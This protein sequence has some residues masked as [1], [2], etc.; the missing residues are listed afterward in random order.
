VRRVVVTGLGVVTPIGNDVRTYWQNLLAGKNGVGYITRFDASNFSVKIAAEVRNFEPPSIISPKEL[1]R[2]DLFNVFAIQ[3]AKEAIEDAQL[4]MATE[5]PYRVGVL[6][7]SGIGG[8]ELWEKQ[9]MRLLESPSKVSPFFIP[10][11]IVNVASG[12]VAIRWGMKGPN[13]SIVSACASSA[14]AIGE[15]FEL[16]KR[17]DADVMIAGGAEAPVTPLSIAGFANMKALSTRNDAPEKASR[18]FD[19][20]RDGFVV[21]EGAGILVLEELDHAR[22]RGA[23]IYAEIKGYAATADA[24]HVTAPDPTAESQSYAIKMALHKAGVKPDEIDYINAH[25][26][27]TPLNDKIETIAIKKA[28]GDHAYK[29][30]ISSTKSMIGHLLGA[31]G[32]VELIATI[33]SVKEDKVHPTINLEEPDPE[34]DLDYVPDGTR[35]MKVRYAI[36]NSFGFGGHNAVIL[37]SK[38]EG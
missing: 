28:L 8:L 12:D 27:S 4:N 3:A 29:V 23:K 37:V 36:S 11:M 13:Y 15:A 38:Y 17:G 19:K 20:Y 7:S 16:I 30:A 33:L 1:R 9:H 6:V 31:A 35:D 22:R 24:Y 14:H 26:T 34:C 21:G 25:G 5:D 2:M 18:P 32:A 10:M